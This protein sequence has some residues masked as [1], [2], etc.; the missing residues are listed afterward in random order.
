M[1]WCPGPE[2][3][4]TALFPATASDDK[5]APTAQHRRVR[6]GERRRRRTVPST[7]ARSAD[8]TEPFTLRRSEVATERQSRTTLRS[9]SFVSTDR[10]QC[11]L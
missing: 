2:K 8:P 10:H 6:T 11:A 5:H 9:P 7:V 4:P 1:Q 3:L